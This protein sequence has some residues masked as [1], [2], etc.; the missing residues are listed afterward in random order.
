M[1][2][3]KIFD[4]HELQSAAN[5]IRSGKLVAFP[6]ETIYGLGADATNP[7]ACAEIYAVKGRPSD[8]PLIV[9]V[10]DIV[11]AEKIA[12]VCPVARKLFE[13]FAPGPITVVMPHRKGILA[14]KKYDD[15]GVGVRIPKHPVAQEFLTLAGVPVAAPSANISG[16][17]SPTTADMV[18][19]DMD[20]KI[21]GIIQS[22]DIECGLESTV[23]SVLDGTVKLLRAGTISVE[24]V[25]Q[26]LGHPITVATNPAAGECV[27]SPGQ[28]YKHYSPAVP[29]E[30]IDFKD[31]GA[32][33]DLI[34]KYRNQK[35]GVLTMQNYDNIPANW[36]VRVFKNLTDYAKNLYSTMDRMGNSGCVK[37]IA[38][39]PPDVGIGCAIRDRLIRGSG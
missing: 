7:A 30:L 6:T 34:T 19:R 35:I 2:Q 24:Q 31:V 22:D 18:A 32:F 28:K 9:H 17:L 26:C 21:D 29:L 5:L 13:T 8:N 33:C 15:V 14:D 39:L 37:I 10:A 1:R 25:E 38:M 27:S 11:A 20:G 12:H 4:T 16:R 23:V 3:T 36:D